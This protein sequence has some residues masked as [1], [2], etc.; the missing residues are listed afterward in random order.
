MPVTHK[1]TLICDEIR[2]EDNGKFL[3]IGLY[4]GGILVPQI[5]F[6]LPSLTF[7]T[8]LESDMP[9]DHAL[10]FKLSALESGKT[11]IE[12]RGHIE[13][14]QPGLIT[15]PIRLPNVQL[16]DVGVYT[17]S[18]QLGDAHEPAFVIQFSVN[19]M[20]PKYSKENS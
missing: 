8:Y 5:P 6:P 20:L 16:Q 18:V 1:F 17:F 14:K 2:R 19:L 13:M 10:K 11:V 7:F 4:T 9:G 12:G 3:V 15:V